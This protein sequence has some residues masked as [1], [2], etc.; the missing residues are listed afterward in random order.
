MLN[1]YFSATGLS[2]GT[3]SPTETQVYEV[4]DARESVAKCLTCGLKNID[5]VLCKSNRASF[6]TGFKYFIHSC[7]GPGTPEY[8]IRLTEV[9][10]YNYFLFIQIEIISR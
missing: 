3:V 4:V 9:R 2:N 6:S 8:H 10:K 1:R 7:S 5:Q